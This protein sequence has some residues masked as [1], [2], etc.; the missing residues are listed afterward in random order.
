MATS[1]GG[2]VRKSPTTG[3]GASPVFTKCAGDPT[4]LTH[5]YGSVANRDRSTSRPDT[6]GLSGGRERGH[7]T[8]HPGAGLTLSIKEEQ[9]ASPDH[10]QDENGARWH[11]SWYAEWHM[12]VYRA[13]GVLK[14]HTHAQEETP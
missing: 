13:A 2:C 7:L 9:N 6:V 8:E 14:K 1:S 12:R 5:V 4:S 10:P 11:H 3:C